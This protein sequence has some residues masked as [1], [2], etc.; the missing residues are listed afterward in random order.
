MK[1]ARRRNIAEHLTYLADGGVDAHLRVDEHA[2]SPQPF[3]DLCPRHQLAVPLQQE[4]QQIHWSP[5]EADRLPPPPQRIGGDVEV[6]FAEPEGVVRAR[7]LQKSSA[8]GQLLSMVP[9]AA[10]CHYAC[11]TG[12]S[13]ISPHRRIR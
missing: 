10:A 6:E 12:D 1:V 13:R 5:L 8:Y 7:H 2:V 11:A 4:D 9:P 3:D